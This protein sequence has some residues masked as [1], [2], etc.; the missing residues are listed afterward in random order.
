[1]IKVVFSFILIILLLACNKTDKTITKNSQSD[2]IITETTSDLTTIEKGEKERMRNFLTIIKTD[3]IDQKP[4][5][6]YLNNPNVNILCKRLY[7]G[8]FDV[9]DNNETF[10]VLKVISQKNDTLYP[11]YFH[12]LNAICKVSDGALS[13]AIGEPCFEMVYNYPVYSFHKFTQQPELMESFSSFIGY[14]LGF[15]SDNTSAIETS[16]AE[17]KKQL[18]KKLNMN[19]SQVKKTYENFIKAIDIEIGNMKN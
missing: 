18:C 12:C 14:E 17:F 1:M 16:Y 13:E 11:F 19:D 6:Y 8:E 4:I 10:D 9:T 15:Q 7:N 2:S 3:A 5:A